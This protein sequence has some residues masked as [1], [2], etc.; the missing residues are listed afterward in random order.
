MIVKKKPKLPTAAQIKAA[1]GVRKKAAPK[2]KTVRK[3]PVKKTVIKNHNPKGEVWGYRVDIKENGKWVAFSKHLRA[4]DAIKQA[5]FI[6]PQLN[7]EARAV[8]IN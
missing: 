4:D 7:R 1:Y 5:E 3:N 6:A 2:K 8:K